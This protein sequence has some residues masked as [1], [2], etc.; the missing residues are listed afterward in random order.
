[1]RNA[2]RSV[3]ITPWR[4]ILMATKKA[5][6]TSQPGQKTKAGFIPAEISASD[7]PDYVVVEL[8]YEAPV[9]FSAAKFAA[10]AAAARQAEALKSILAKF[11]IIHALVEGNSLRATARLS[12]TAFNTVA[13]LFVDA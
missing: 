5:R 6:S 7:I 13:K 10:P 12:D 1:M 8:R 9:A 11:D 2:A 4:R 3:G